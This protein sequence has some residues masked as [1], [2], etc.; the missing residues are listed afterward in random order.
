M[1]SHDRTEH[2]INVS[3]PAIRKIP[4]AGKAAATAVGS[5]Q[6]SLNLI[7]PRILIHFKPLC[8]KKQYKRSNCTQQA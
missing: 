7:D 8:H 1:V 3:A 2:A 4:A 5:R 6:L